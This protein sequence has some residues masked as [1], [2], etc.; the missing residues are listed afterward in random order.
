MNPLF[1]FGGGRKFGVMGDV[2]LG[3]D[4][5]TLMVPATELSKFEEVALPADLYAARSDANGSIRNEIDS[6]PIAAMGGKTIVEIVGLET[7]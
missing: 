6:S 1:E 4:N 2:F 7:M 3:Q 5:T